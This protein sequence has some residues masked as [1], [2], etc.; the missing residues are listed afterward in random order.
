MKFVF[1]SFIVGFASSVVVSF[2]LTEK[3]R[4]RRLLWESL[5]NKKITE[6]EVDAVIYQKVT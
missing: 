4:E 6:D 5:N 2:H 3:L 1:S